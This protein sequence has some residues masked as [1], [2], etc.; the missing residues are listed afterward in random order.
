MR[1]TISLPDPLL[2]TAKQY[3]A[4]RRVTLS[5]VLEDALRCFLAKPPAPKTERFQL[6]TVAGRLVDPGLDLD[7]TSALFTREDESTFRGR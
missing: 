5:V 3:A 7:R 6:H 4:S 2:E 1:T